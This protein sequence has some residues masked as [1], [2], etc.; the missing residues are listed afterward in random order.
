[1]KAT[2]KVQFWISKPR[3]V[4]C[5]TSHCILRFVTEIFYLRVTGVGHKEKFQGHSKPIGGTCEP[6]LG[7]CAQFQ[8]APIGLNRASI[9]RPEE[10]LKMP[11]ITVGHE[12][13]LLMIA[14]L[15]LLPACSLA[16]RVINRDE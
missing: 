10:A 11:R 13:P 14:V 12:Y 16:T 5:P 4:K 2:N 3:S 8:I 7:V 15:L 6:S 1:M 9:D